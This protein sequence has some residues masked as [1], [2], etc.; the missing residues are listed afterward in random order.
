MPLGSIANFIG[1]GLGSVNVNIPLNPLEYFN[2]SDQDLG[3]GWL[4]LALG[5][6]PTQ[7]AYAVM[8]P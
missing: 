6:R 5:L 1:L 3:L 8:V 7:T 2:I 4:D